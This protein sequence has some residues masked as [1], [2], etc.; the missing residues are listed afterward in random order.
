MF[1]CFPCKSADCTTAICKCCLRRCFHSSSPGLEAWGE[2]IAFLCSEPSWHP[3]VQRESVFEM[4]N[5]TKKR[6]PQV[7]IFAASC[8]ANFSIVESCNFKCRWRCNFKLPLLKKCTLFLSA[9]TVMHRLSL[10]GKTSRQLSASFPLQGAP[11]HPGTEQ[12]WATSILFVQKP[13]KQTEPTAKRPP[14][15]APRVWQRNVQTLFP[16]RDG[17]FHLEL[18]LPVFPVRPSAVRHKGEALKSWRGGV[19]RT[20]CHGG[21]KHC[22]CERP[23]GVC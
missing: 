12:R 7:R 23:L 13:S 18:H 9:A 2:K 4:L 14:P 5:A 19:E 3:Q 20:P 11:R 16:T 6:V 1:Y 21:G 17:R 8:E 15:K 22:D 10:A